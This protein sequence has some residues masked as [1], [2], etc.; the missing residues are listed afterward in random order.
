MASLFETVLSYFDA[1]GWT[2]R[3]LPGRQG[4]EA[5]VEGSTAGTSSSRWSTAMRS[6]ASSRSSTAA[7]PRRAAARSTEFVARANYGLLLGNFE[8]D[9]NDGELRYKTSI[10][11]ED[12]TLSQ[13]QFPQPP[14]RSLAALDRYLP[15]LQ[16][17][18]QGTADPAA[19]VAD[20]EHGELAPSKPGDREPGS[21]DRER[22]T[23]E[24]Q[25]VGSGTGAGVAA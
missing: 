16:R 5:G 7:C 19:A 12:S 21:G 22:D 15:H 11:L 6:S 3:H 25:P 20:A 18:M 2:Y 14:V 4:I 8:F 24:R 13:A 9:V 1:E 10:D 23:T 17:V